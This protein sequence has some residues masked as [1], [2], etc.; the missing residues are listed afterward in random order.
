MHR[1]LGHILLITQHF[2]GCQDGHQLAMGVFPCATQ[3]I[4]STLSSVCLRLDSPFRITVGEVGMFHL[5][6]MI[7]EGRPDPDCNCSLLNTAFKVRKN[8]PYPL[9]SVKARDNYKVNLQALIAFS[10][11]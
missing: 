5:G 9:S 3:S 7:L 6:W 4:Q 1:M 8:L 10:I 2:S 11:P